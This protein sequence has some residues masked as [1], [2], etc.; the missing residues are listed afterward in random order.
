MTDKFYEL[1]N[2]FDRFDKEDDEGVDHVDGY[3]EEFDGC[4]DL[5]SAFS[6][7]VPIIL[8]GD[9]GIVERVPTEEGIWR[10]FEA[11]M[12]EML[13]FT[14]ERKYLSMTDFP[15]IRNAWSW[16]IM[17]MRM[18]EILLSVGDFPH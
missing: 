3:L 14:G 9:K 10:L 17:S 1:S 7:C 8:D 6:D 18:V 5:E 4:G 2:N 16:P 13:K 15:R 12:P 11:K